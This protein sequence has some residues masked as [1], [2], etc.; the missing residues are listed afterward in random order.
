LLV[1]FKTPIAFASKGLT[2]TEIGY[3]VIEKEMLDILFGCKRF[4]QFTYGREVIV[5]CDHIPISAIIKIP[6]SAAPPA[7]SSVKKNS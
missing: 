2:Q 7:T 6:M 1:Y 4:H 5:Y 3:A